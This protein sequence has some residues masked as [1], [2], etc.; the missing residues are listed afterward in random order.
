MARA[1]VAALIREYTLYARAVSHHALHN[2]IIE[3]HISYQYED[4]RDGAIG[5]LC[6]NVIDARRVFISRVVASQSSENI[7]SPARAE[8]RPRIWRTLERI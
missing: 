4:T 2:I 6:A 7:L 5:V 3:Y 8:Q 1:A